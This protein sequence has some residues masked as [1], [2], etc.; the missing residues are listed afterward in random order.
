MVARFFWLCPTAH[1]LVGCRD[2]LSRVIHL[3]QVVW[4]IGRK[5]RR[6]VGDEFWARR[7]QL[8]KK[9]EVIDGELLWSDE[10]RITSGP[11]AGA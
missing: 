11:R 6:W 7:E 9:F 10:E 2:P 3:G 1:P 4:N 8:P 5:G